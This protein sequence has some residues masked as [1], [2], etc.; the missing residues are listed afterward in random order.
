M[1]VKESERLPDK[2]NLMLG[3]R[4]VLE[5]AV[6]RILETCAFDQVIVFSRKEDISVQGSLTVYDESEG[7]LIDSIRLCL[8]QFHEFFA[9]GGDMPFLD[10]KVIRTMIRHYKG[11]PLCAFSSDGTLQPLHAIYNGSV[12]NDLTEA[13]KAGQRSVYGFISSSRFSLFRVDSPTEEIFFSINTGTDYN[14]ALRRI[15]SSTG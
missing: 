5:H 13:I 6:S 8:K 4:S 1:F 14:E 3:N 9:F 2:H 15:K 7:V 12:L 10:P 11:T